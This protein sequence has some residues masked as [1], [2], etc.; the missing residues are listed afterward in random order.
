MKFPKEHAATDELS[1]ATGGVGSVSST[2]TTAANAVITTQD[3]AKL[4]DKAKSPWPDTWRQD[5]ANNDEKELKQ[6]ERYASPSDIWK[7]AR[8]LEQRLSSGE[9]KTVSPFPDKG[10]DEQKNAWRQEHG[11]PLSPDKYDL[12]LAPGIAV[13][14][15]DKPVVD[16][17]LAYAHTKNLPNDV[18]SAAVQWYFDFQTK[19][20]ENRAEHNAQVRKETEDAL[21]AEW[22]PEYRLNR[23]TID[24]LLDGRV[25]AD[26]ELRERIR[27]AVDTNV[28]F[29]KLLSGLA[30]EINPV[31]TLIPGSGNSPDK[32]ESEITQWNAKMADA[33]SD[34]WKG[35]NAEK[36][37]ERYRQLVAARDKIKG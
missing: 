9:L 35:P 5:L 7:K 33:N 13:G 20:A 23:T 6:L 36:N 30:R 19:E 31:A 24:N 37:Q 25:P 27:I 28:E 32:L 12:K 4:Q 17:F 3:Q 15:E 18:A 16:D 8:A 2:D 26:S 14:E 11:I 34:Y 21:R 1:G 10:S 29:A 22:G